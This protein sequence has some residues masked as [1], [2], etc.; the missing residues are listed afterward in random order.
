V[1]FLIDNQLPAALGRLIETELNAE[2]KHVTDLG[3]R[4]AT[5]AEL[6]SY[7][8]AH[9]SIL[10]SKDENFANMVL[11]RPTARLIWV[12]VGNC[13]RVGATARVTTPWLVD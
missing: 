12:R 1:K 2:A 7:V 9:D 8:S 6:W 5:D 13:R 4:D 3:L 10:L 11:Q